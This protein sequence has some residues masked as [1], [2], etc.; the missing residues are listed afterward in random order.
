ML[1][2]EGSLRLDC[3]LWDS[4]PHPGCVSVGEKEKVHGRL[5]GKFGLFLQP[6]LY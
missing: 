6:C 2:G 4:S 1:A 3:L 5:E